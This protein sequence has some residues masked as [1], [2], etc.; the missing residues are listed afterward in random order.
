MFAK[1]FTWIKQEGLPEVEYT[2]VVVDNKDPLQIGR[3]KVMISIF[4]GIDTADLPWVTQKSPSFLGGGLGS[5]FFAVPEEG[6]KIQVFFERREIYNGYYMATLSNK[7]TMVED[8]KEDYPNSYGFKDSQGNILIINKLTNCITLKQK[9]GTQ[10]RLDSDES[11]RLEFNSGSVMKID[12]DDNAFIKHSSG[13]FIKIKQDSDIHE[14]APNILLEGD[15]TI[16]SGSIAMNAGTG[17]TTVTSESNEI[18]GNLKIGKDLEI[19]GNIASTQATNWDEAY[20][21]GDHSS[22]GYI[23]VEE[24]PIF[25][26]WDKKT[27][28]AIDSSQIN[29]FSN[30]GCWQPP[31]IS[32]TD[33]PVN[34]LYYSST[35][36]KLVYKDASGGIHALYL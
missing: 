29:Q 8:F 10:L 36:S 4:K 18:T 23:K 14:K 28:I 2:G 30:N 35:Q 7:V 9:S 20:S 31:D 5:S 17:G 12:K 11:I 15:V 13:S 34:S 1:P 32:D 27:G 16:T 24:D 25:N 22:E 3:V 6:S 19:D 26:G 21:W 33:A